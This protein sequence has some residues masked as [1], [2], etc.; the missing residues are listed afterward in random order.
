MKGNLWMVKKENLFEFD[1]RK[2]SLLSDIKG[3][4]VRYIE[5]KMKDL[6]T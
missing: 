3:Q 2:K 1:V 5:N 6:E 4:Y